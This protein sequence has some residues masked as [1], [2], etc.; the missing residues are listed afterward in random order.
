MTKNFEDTLSCILYNIGGCLMNFLTIMVL[1]FIMNTYI[2]QSSL[3]VYYIFLAAV[4]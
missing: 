1:Y 2:I 3:V 4:Y